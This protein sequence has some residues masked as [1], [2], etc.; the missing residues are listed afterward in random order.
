MMDQTMTVVGGNV[1]YVLEDGRRVISPI[2][3][4]RPVVKRG[5]VVLL[6]I[7]CPLCRRKH[8]HDISEGT[9]LPHCDDPELRKLSY[10]VLPESCAEP[11]VRRFADQSEKWLEALYA[12]W[13]AIRETKRYWR[14]RP[15]PGE[16]PR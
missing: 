13:A 3:V 14:T 15:G 9:R 6:R 5:K 12:K 8:D 16:P 4:G 10:Y 11:T 1:E 2:V 7:K